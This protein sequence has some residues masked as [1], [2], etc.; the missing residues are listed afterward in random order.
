MPDS[1]TNFTEESESWTPPASAAYPDPLA[2]E[3]FYGLVGEIVRAIEPHTE[4]D[5]VA[6]L[7]QLL[8]GIGNLIGRTPTLMMDGAAHHAN[9]FAVLVGTT[10][11][12]RKGTSWRQT[13]RV[14]AMT[15]PKWADKRITGG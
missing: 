8:V 10:A 12:A 14:L 2:G 3:A 6:L 15:D 9:L 7:L 5:P 4:S 11:K 1:F 13:R